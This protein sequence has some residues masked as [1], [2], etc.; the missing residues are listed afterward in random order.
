MKIYQDAETPWLSCRISTFK[1]S[2]VPL[3]GASDSFNHNKRAFLSAGLKD[4][5]QNMTRVASSRIKREGPN[6]CAET[7]HNATQEQ[8]YQ[9]R[10]LK[11]PR[12]EEEYLTTEPDWDQFRNPAPG[13]W[14]TTN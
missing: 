4:A 10:E 14:D 2:R 7:L 9:N 12:L 6:R 3:E 5:S 11:R 1:E 8:A 13:G